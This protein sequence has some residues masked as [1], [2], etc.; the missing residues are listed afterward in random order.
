MRHYRKGYPPD[1]IARLETLEKEILA[2]RFTLNIE[3]E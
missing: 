3:N 1:V 2:N